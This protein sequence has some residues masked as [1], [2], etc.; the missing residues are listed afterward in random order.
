MAWSPDSKKLM[1]CS[2]DK[3]VKIWNMDEKNFISNKEE[4]YVSF[5]SKTLQNLKRNI[6]ILVK[7]CFKRF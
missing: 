3:T 6:I 7:L 1:T 4:M 2:A 5:N